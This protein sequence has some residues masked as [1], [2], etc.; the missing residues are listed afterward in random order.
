MLSTHSTYSQDEKELYSVWFSKFE[1]ARHRLLAI[2]RQ[3]GSQE[4]KCMGIVIDK[5]VSLNTYLKFCESEPRIIV[6]Y[7]L[8]DRKIEAYDMPDESHASVHGKLNYIMG[9]WN[10]QL[11][12]SIERDVIVSARSVYRGDIYVRPKYFRP[13]QPQQPQPPRAG[14]NYPNLV[15]EIGNTESLRNLHE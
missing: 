7:C 12:I 11:S 14:R 9:G 10:D 4:V 15:V 6:K 8:I 3:E 2:D 13:Q 5:E 1:L